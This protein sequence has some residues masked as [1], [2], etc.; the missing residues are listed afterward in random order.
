[1]IL[2]FIITISIRIIVKSRVSSPTSKYMRRVE[3]R[4]GRRPRSGRSWRRCTGRT[5]RGSQGE[6]LQTRNHTK[7]KFHW[8]MP[9]KVHWNFPVKIHWGSDNARENTTEKWTSF[10]KC[11]WKSIGK[12][13]WKSTMISELLISGVQYFAPRFVHAMRHGAMGAFHGR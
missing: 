11:R 7:A 3:M 5:R 9:Q 4:A 2:W 13:H 12:C 6:R 10:G 8:K 1:M